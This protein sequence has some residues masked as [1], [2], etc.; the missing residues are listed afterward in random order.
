[1]LKR[2]RTEY[3][4]PGNL[5]NNSAVSLPTDAIAVSAP[6]LGSVD[7]AMLGSPSS[8]FSISGSPFPDLFSSGG[9]P[10]PD[11]GT[12]DDDVLDIFKTEELLFKENARL[13][14]TNKQLM[15]ELESSKKLNTAHSRRISELRA[16]IIA[17]EDYV[18]ALKSEISAMEGRMTALKARKGINYQA[19]RPEDIAL[20]SQFKSIAGFAPTDI[21]SIGALI[22]KV[23]QVVG[24]LTTKLEES[25][26]A[27]EALRSRIPASSEA[28]PIGFFG[29]AAAPSSTPLEVTTA[30]A[31]SR[32]AQ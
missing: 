21:V 3:S 28:K 32:T 17:M 15:A 26:A 1:M 27:Q 23:I 14:E 2:P 7:D 5:P 18:K 22:T 24:D 11:L 25:K 16:E 19:N 9:S 10:L 6:A 12:L 31:L 8:L 20:M 29:A 13:E 4:T 30:G